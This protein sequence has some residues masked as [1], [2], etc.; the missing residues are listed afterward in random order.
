MEVLFCEIDGRVL[1]LME[2]VFCELDDRVLAAAGG[3]IVCEFC[4]RV[5]G[6]AICGVSRGAVW[7]D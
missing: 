4:C 3:G 1:L 6:N 7:R 2:V 5:L